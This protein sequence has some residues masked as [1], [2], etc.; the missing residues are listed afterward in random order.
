MFFTML[1]IS[2]ACLGLLG[3]ISNKLGEK[4]KEIGIRKVLGARVYHVGRILLNATVKQIT[5]STIIGL[6]I[7]Y[8][9]A[10]EYLEN[11]L[12]ELFCTGGTLQF[13]LRCCSLSCL[14]PF[15]RYYLKLSELTRSSH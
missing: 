15:S 11:F 10:Q 9:F 14:L 7:A 13:L 4:T 2:I 3:M 1:A 6:P 5:L 8:Y 12:S